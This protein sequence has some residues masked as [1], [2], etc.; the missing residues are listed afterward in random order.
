ML[1]LSELNKKL[2]N[3]LK[4][5]TKESLELFIKEK[6]TMKFYYV[7]FNVGKAKYVLNFHDGVKTHKDGSKFYDM[8]IFSNK[9][10][11]KKAIKQLQK[12]G[13]KSHNN[14]L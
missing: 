1:N 13:Y 14:S 8:K 5:E 2:N 10:E 4:N 12:E 3:A 9:K 11:L 6:R 7:Q